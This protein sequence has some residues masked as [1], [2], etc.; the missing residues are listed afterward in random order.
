MTTE[1][2]GGSNQGMWL[3]TGCLVPGLFG[4]FAEKPSEEVGYGGTQDQ[5]S[6]G[7]DREAAETREAQDYGPGSGVGA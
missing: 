3:K 7:G 6:T 4:I 2:Q 5:T 1:S